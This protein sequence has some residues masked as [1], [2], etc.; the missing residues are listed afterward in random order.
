MILE[1]VQPFLS[2]RIG[3]DLASVG[4]G[5]VLAA[6][7]Q[8]MS[9]LG[10]SEADYALRLST[11]AEEQAALIDAIVVS[12]SW[13]FR[14]RRPFRRLADFARGRSQL[15]VLSVPC[16]AGEE[17]YSIAITL[18]LAGVP[19][20]GIVV[21]G[22][23]ISHR[24]IEAARAGFYRS[25]AFR[26]PLDPMQQSYFEVHGSVHAIRRDVKE[27]VNFTQGNLLS[28]PLAFAQAPFDVVFCRNLL[29]YITESA[30]NRIL[31][32]LWQLLHNDGLLVVG[33]AEAAIVST[34]QF[35]SEGNQ[36]DYCF[37]ARSPLPPPQP[38]FPLVDFQV[39][40]R[41]DVVL[42]DRHPNVVPQEEVFTPG[43]EDVHQLTATRNYDEA[44]RICDEV[45]RRSPTAQALALRGM[46]A[47]AQ[48][49]ANQA[50]AWLQK[51]VYLNPDDEDSL[52]TL[53]LLAE[54]R[55]DDRNASRYRVRAQRA[56]RQREES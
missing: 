50:A 30:R 15:R 12:E 32:T 39:S 2:E 36:G 17:A 13:F 47:L 11:S 8:R 38:V 52:L 56:R 42:P 41:Q 51:A 49:Q 26:D 34:A 55:G 35:I 54:R 40:S 25:I 53:A 27:L 14:D 16:A 43:L 21:E 1:V 20:Q 9:V 4:E 19:H 22:V 23:D 10:D 18:L 6:V 48:G 5:Y 44:A 24:A 46:I 37:R 29:I 31:T 33:H 3:M 28:L 45:I 7:R